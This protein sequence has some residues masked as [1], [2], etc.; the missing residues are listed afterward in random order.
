VELEAS[1]TALRAYIEQALAAAE[2]DA[3]RPS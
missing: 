3:A 1:D 2:T